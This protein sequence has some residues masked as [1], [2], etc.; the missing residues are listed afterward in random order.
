MPRASEIKKGHI[1]EIDGHIYI[2][3]QIEVKSPSSRGSNTLYKIRFTQ[4]Q[5]GLK[6][7]ETFTGDDMVTEV[8]LIRRP[9]QFLYRD[10]DAFSFMDQEDYNQ[11]TLNLDDLGEDADYLTDGIEGLQLLLVDGEILGIQLPPSVILLITDTVPALKGGT[12]TARSK[13]ATLETGLVVQVPEYIANGEKIK[14][15]TETGKFM[16]RA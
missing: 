1:V 8:D 10:G 4:F 11:F 12:A 13:P 15:N 2:A 16:S 7:D 3:K 9:G 5:T 6:R 14:V